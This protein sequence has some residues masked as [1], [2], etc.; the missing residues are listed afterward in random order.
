LVN[1]YYGHRNPVSVAAFLKQEHWPCL[2]AFFINDRNKPASA[3]VL[4]LLPRADNWSSNKAPKH[5]SMTFFKSNFIAWQHVQHHDTL[6]VVLAMTTTRAAAT[7]AQAQNKSSSIVKSTFK[8]NT[9]RRPLAPRRRM[10]KACQQ[11]DD[12]QVAS[13]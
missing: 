8:R 10:M 3:H 9:K 4:V 7:R 2:L 13:L 6:I 5:A 11:R 1:I 12:L